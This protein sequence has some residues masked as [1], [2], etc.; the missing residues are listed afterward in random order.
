MVSLG[1]SEDFIQSMTNQEMKKNAC[2]KFYT[3]LSF[4]ER[5]SKLGE[6]FSANDIIVCLFSQ[7]P[8]FLLLPH[9]LPSHVLQPRPR[10]SSSLFFHPLLW[11]S[12]HLTT[13]RSYF[14]L[15]E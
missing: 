7:V 12:F 10:R 1:A 13:W 4:Q 11:P 8:A 15:K 3:Q 2:A 5:G 9:H 14:C 6:R